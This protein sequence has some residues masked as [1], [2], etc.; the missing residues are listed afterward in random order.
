MNHAALPIG[1]IV[2]FGWIRFAKGNELGHRFGWKVFFHNKGKG[3]GTDRCDRFKIFQL[4][5]QLVVQVR[6]DRESCACRKKQGIAILGRARDCCGTNRCG[7]SDLVFNDKSLPQFLTQALAKLAAH[8]IA[9]SARGVR[10]H[11]GYRPGRPIGSLRSLSRNAHGRQRKQS[12]RGRKEGTFQRLIHCCLLNLWIR[13]NRQV[14]FNHFRAVKARI[15][16]NRVGRQSAPIA[17]A[18]HIGQALKLAPAD[19]RCSTPTSTD[20]F[21][22]PNPRSAAPTHTLKPVRCWTLPTANGTCVGPSPTF[23]S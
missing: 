13:I 18:S 9:G 22:C 14:K 11:Q 17:H 8:H 15:S 3:H 16:L 4:V 21:S 2:D 12:E 20:S 19:A 23:W 7:S 1:R 6:N 5:L 10:Y